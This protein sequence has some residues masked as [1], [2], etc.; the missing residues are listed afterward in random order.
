MVSF[1]LSLGARKSPIGKNEKRSFRVEKG[2]RCKN[3]VTRYTSSVLL[4]TAL[5][6]DEI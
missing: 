6:F 2:Q 4:E 3:V 5:R 1:F